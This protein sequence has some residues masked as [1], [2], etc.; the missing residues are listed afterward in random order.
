MLVLVRCV[1]DSNSFQNPGK[2][3]FATP[4]HVH[5][6]QGTSIGCRV[7]EARGDL[8]EFT[9]LSANTASRMALLR[10]K[11]ASNGRD[12]LRHLAIIVIS[13][14]QSLRLLA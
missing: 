6:E 1:S 4:R 9:H 7:L 5:V 3:S 12:D 13:M 10:D 8:A 11:I 2:R 14:L